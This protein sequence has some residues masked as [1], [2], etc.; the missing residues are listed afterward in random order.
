MPKYHQ[1]KFT[2][3]NPDKYVGT[4]P[5]VAR[6][7]WE[8]AVM[9]M[10]DSHP[11]IINWASESIKIPYYNPISRKQS[12][13]VPDFLFVYEDMN[14]VRH[15]ELIEVKPASQ[16]SLKEAKTKSDKIALAINAYKWKAAEVFCKR[17]G[18]KFRVV[19]EDHLF[20]KPTKRRR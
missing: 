9:R 18:L 13:Y 2:P 14:G 19:T 11:N 16:S 3:K 8:L 20:V 10:A 15:S 7:S 4:Y 6:S 1:S 5:I 12:I 17:H